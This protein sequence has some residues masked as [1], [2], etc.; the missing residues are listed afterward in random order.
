MID[1]EL[2]INEQEF[3]REV[4]SLEL[5]AI[6]R[7]VLM[8]ESVGRETIA[9]LRSLTEETRPALRV[10]QPNRRAHPGGWADVTS[11]LANSYDFTVTREGTRGVVLTLLNSAEHAAYLEAR[12]GYFVLRG[13]TEPGGPVDKAIRAAVRV[14]AP[15]W[16]VD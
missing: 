12:D 4:A 2:S 13:V 8:L 10:G 3:A 7:L 5:L 1:F 11:Q 14:V 6:E 9:F 16:R 15:D